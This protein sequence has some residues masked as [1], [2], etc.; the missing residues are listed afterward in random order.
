MSEKRF[1]IAPLDEKTQ[2]PEL[3]ALKAMI[4]F[5]EPSAGKMAAVFVK[6]IEVRAV[7]DYFD[8]GVAVQ[9]AGRDRSREMLAA[10]RPYC[11]EK[12]SETVEFIGKMLEMK[13]MAETLRAIN[14]M[15]ETGGPIQP[16]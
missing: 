2:T 12:M 9:S 14:A 1:P 13:D 10:I 6:M 4:P 7:I 16:E 15:N 11:D 5:M 8:S 3:M